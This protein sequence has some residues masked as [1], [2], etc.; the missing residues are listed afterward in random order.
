VLSIEIAYVGPQGQWLLQASLPAG[1][2]VADAIAA[3]GLVQKVAGL[4][5][6]DDHVGIHGHRV[7]LA[8]ALAD[9]D[10][11]EIYRPLVADPKEARRRRARR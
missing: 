9:G 10:R 6:D 3:S 2:T 5:V 1:A 4:V 7:A 11:V 8:A